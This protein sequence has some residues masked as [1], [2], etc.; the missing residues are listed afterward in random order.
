[1]AVAY[2][3]LVGLGAAL[4]S[5]AALRT[6][7]PA[8]KLAV[9]AAEPPPETE[10]RSRAHRAGMPVESPE[11]AAP[12]EPPPQRYGQIVIVTLREGMGGMFDRLA[13]ET[14][15]QIEANEPETLVYTCH[16]VAGVPQQRIFYELY[17]DRVAF[18]RHESQPYV[19]RFYLERERYV[20]ATNVVRLDLNAAKGI[21]SASNAARQS[22]RS[23]A[24]T[25]ADPAAAH[26]ARPSDDARGVDND[27]GTTTRTDRPRV[28]DVTAQGDNGALTQA[29][30]EWDFL[31]RR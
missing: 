11:P 17:H 23:A 21:T 13:E 30:D 8:A 7:D 6:R 31:Y 5:F 28:D 10:R 2:V 16:T 1:P 12:P 29:D 24:A 15:R 27:N 9:A 14:V 22:G 20:L 25:Q 3:F 19:Q 26:A 4:L 18:S